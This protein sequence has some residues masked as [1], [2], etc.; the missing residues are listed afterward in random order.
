MPKLRPSKPPDRATS[1]RRMAKALRV[2][3]RN[4]GQTLTPADAMKQIADELEFEAKTLR[5]K[6]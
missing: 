3:A 1:F 5:A 6:P 2:R 4:S